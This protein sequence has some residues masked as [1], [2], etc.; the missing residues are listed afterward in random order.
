MAPPSATHLRDAT[1]RRTARWMNGLGRR[2]HHL[3]KHPNAACRHLRRANK[4]RM[5]SARIA[6]A[7][8][9]NAPELNGE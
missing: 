2:R 7:L 5:R 9:L 1:T 6:R 3:G 4:A 8:E